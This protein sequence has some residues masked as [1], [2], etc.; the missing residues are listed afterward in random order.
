MRH[1]LSVTFPEW[2]ANGV[3]SI[4]PGPPCYKRRV[5]D[6]S[7]YPAVPG[8]TDRESFFAAQARHRRASGWFTLLAAV[9]I[10]MMG[11][12]L[13]AVISPLLYAAAVI[14][15]DLVNL[16]V[17]M[18]DLLRFVAES[19]S[20]GPTGPVPPEVVA[21]AVVAVVGPGS[22][23]LLLSWLG[24]RRLFR[25]AG[26]GGTVAALGARP[27]SAAL[28]ERQLA[29][30]V[31][32]M[33]VAA[34]LRPPD[35]ML[36]DSPVPNAAAVGSGIDDATV[37]VT[38][39]LLATLDR[40]ETQGVVAHLVASVGNGDLRIGTTISSVFQTL[41][42]V[43]S[44]LRAP[45][46]GSPRTTLRRLLRYAFRRSP[47]EGAALAEVLVRAGGAWDESDYVD[48]DPGRLKS[49]LLLPFLVAGGAFQLTSG[50]FGMMVVNPFLRRAW[51]ARRHLAD[52]SAV[53]LTRNPDGLARALGT[54]SQRGGVVPGTEW[55]AHL[56]A[57]GYAAPPE[58]Q[59]SP[60]PAF[61]PPVAKRLDRL[62]RMGASSAPRAVK[63]PLGQRLALA[64]VVLVTSPC[65][66][67]MAALLLGTA[68]IMTGVSLAIDM[69]FLAPMVALVH[70]V[71][72]NLAG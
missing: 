20:G 59:V 36:L 4:M 25:R 1:N 66:L 26:A 7:A 32:E 35:V 61:Q 68:I 29:N 65:W 58:K 45:S 22:V 71:L 40:D 6:M 62:A 11:I 18:P 13:S 2:D 48:E 41:G 55:A 53:Q 14:V 44:V 47:D 9:A 60:M 64:A 3:F 67:P 69:L 28:E 37:V 38:T 46:E 56:F 10:A 51:R 42:L 21:L 17:P 52:A 50:I 54:L 19:E 57:V 43:G 39:G 30:L 8:P 23:T 5:T 12:P 72:R 15:V 63:T 70:V 16:L 34:G 31:A 33:A 27:P 24:V 49:V